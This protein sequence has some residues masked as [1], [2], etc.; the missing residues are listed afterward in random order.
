MISLRCKSCDGVLNIDEDRE[1]LCCPFCGSKELMEESDEVRKERI[2]YKT[3]KD[4]ALGSL[5]I[6]RQMKLDQVEL[7][8]QRMKE[9]SKGDLR[10]LLFAVGCFLLM[11]ILG[12]LSDV[13]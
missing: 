5:E 11:I 1:I 4:I 13:L 10:L 9:D 2:K 7:E 6:E 3:Q 12:L 8:R